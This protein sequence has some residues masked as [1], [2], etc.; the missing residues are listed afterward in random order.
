LDPLEDGISLTAELTMPSAGHRE[1]AVIELDDPDIWV[2][3]P[4]IHRQG[5]RLTATSRLLSMDGGSFAVD[6]SAVRITVLGSEHTVDIRGC[7][8]G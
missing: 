8:G 4:D 6:R 3:E 7:T 1:M 2:S 5:N